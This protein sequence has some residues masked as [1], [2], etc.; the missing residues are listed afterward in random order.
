MSEP[1]EATAQPKPEQASPASES[2]APAQQPGRRERR[3]MRRRLKDFEHERE[4]LLL[5]LGALVHE[6]QL[7]GRREPRLLL[8]KAA[9]LAAV[10]GELRRLA[11]ELGDPRH[12]PAQQTCSFCA[13][14]CEPGQLVCL[15]CGARFEVE[16]RRSTHQLPVAV[17]ALVV[18]LIGSISVLAY[19]ALDDNGNDN[20]A[21][22]ADGTPAAQ[23]EVD[24][25]RDGKRAKK[26]LPQASPRG[27]TKARAV[28]G[29]PAKGL[30]KGGATYRWPKD[31]SGYTV[32]LTSNGDLDSAKSFAESS[33]QDG[34][35]LGVLHSDDFSSLEA[36]FWMVF[37]GRYE[38]AGEAEQAATELRDRFG[39][40]F[41]QQIKP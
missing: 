16:E 9:E 20:R 38:T 29:G 13:T 17:L 19:A 34:D 25:N 24:L 35:Q 15:S 8:P 11:R 39:A 6:L 12:A 14:S 36:G 10:D 41:A 3:R 32:V 5:D 21:P 26:A 37:A 1:D 28:T 23:R 18:G 40:A 33:A 7:H 2:T 27:P 31:L 4:A 30:V 22:A